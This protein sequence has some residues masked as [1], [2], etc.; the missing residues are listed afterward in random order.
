M[1]D[2]RL[3]LLDVLF[4]CPL[5]EYRDG[6][7]AVQWAE[8]LVGRTGG[9]HVPSLNLL[10]AAQAERGDFAAATRTSE[11]AL[12]LARAER[13]ARLTALIESRLAL[14]RARRPYHQPLA[15]VAGPG[16]S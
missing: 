8:R 15:P 13:N 14:Y 9:R 4:T 6:D 16:P 1:Y 10:A 5:P 2:V 12:A 3:K 7:A 11:R